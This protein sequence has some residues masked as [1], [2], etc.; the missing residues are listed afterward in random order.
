MALW[1]DTWSFPSSPPSR[2]SNQICHTIW[3]TT[4]AKRLDVCEAA[5]TDSYLY[6]EL[7]QQEQQKLAAQQARNEEE[8]AQME[9]E[10]AVL[11]AAQDRMARLGAE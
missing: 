6:P 9:A 8:Q 2:Q 10:Q 4:E 1:F 3:D 5:R 11:T 7:R